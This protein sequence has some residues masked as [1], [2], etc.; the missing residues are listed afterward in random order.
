[1]G[2]PDCHR[3]ALATE[4]RSRS[5]SVCPLWFDMPYLCS[6][7]AEFAVHY[8]LRTVGLPDRSIENYAAG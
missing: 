7:L 5:V 4:A 2:P 1:M 8:R 6:V 3:Y